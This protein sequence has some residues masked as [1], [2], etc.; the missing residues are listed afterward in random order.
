MVI[1]FADVVDSDVAIELFAWLSAFFI[2]IRS[3][4]YLLEVGLMRIAGEDLLYGDFLFACAVNAQ[5]D[6][7]ETASSQQSH[8][9]EL[10]RETVAK[11]LVLLRS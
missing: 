3:E 2:E 6:H 4:P 10:V 8:T 1:Q 7:A 9:F 5:P 11:F